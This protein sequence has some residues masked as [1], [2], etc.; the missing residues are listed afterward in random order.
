[1]GRKKLQ[2][3]ELKFAMIDLVNIEQIV[4]SSLATNELFHT[5]VLASQ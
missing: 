2:D 4:A 5:C 3:E 1:M